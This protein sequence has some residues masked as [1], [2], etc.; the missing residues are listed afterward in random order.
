MAELTAISSNGKCCSVCIVFKLFNEFNNKKCSK[1]DYHSQCEDC[2]RLRELMSISREE[3]RPP[4][5][6]VVDDEPM[7]C[8]ELSLPELKTLQKQHNIII[9]RHY[10]KKE[11]VELLKQRGVLP[12]SYTIGRRRVKKDLTSRTSAEPNSSLARASPVDKRPPGAANSSLPDPQAGSLR[13]AGV[14]NRKHTPK[15]NIR[16]RARRVELKLIDD[17]TEVQVFPSL[18]KAGSSA[19]LVTITI[20]KKI[21]VSLTITITITKIFSITKTI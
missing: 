11:L 1:D 10:N 5:M 13:P 8:E 15:S 14:T 17:E 18:Y 12:A 4:M 7:I 3:D 20:T 21:A 19:I 2:R 9:D 6:I 16:G